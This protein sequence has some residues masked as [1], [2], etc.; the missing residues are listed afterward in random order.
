MLEIVV[1]AEDFLAD[2]LGFFWVNE[3][4]SQSFQDL[5]VLFEELIIKHEILFYLSVWLLLVALVKQI[6]DLGLVDAHLNFYRSFEFADDGDRRERIAPNY[7]PKI[8]G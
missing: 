5:Q 8:G 3:Q 6:E 7:L 2:W 1:K 4:E